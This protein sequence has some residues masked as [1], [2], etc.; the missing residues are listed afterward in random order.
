M[1]RIMFLT[2][3][4]EKNGLILSFDPPNARQDELTIC[5]LAMLLS[6]VSDPCPGQDSA[7]SSHKTLYFLCRQNWS[8]L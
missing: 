2:L 3:G 5:E 4:Q 1:K 7:P 8:S 6:D